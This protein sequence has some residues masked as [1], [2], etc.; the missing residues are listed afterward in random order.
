MAGKIQS[1]V[2]ECFEHKIGGGSSSDNKLLLESIS[3]LIK[4]TEKEKSLVNILY[5]ALQSF[6]SIFCGMD[7]TRTR[8]PLRDRQVF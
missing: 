3:N 1:A 8:D 5:K 7:G 6:A 4:D 2:A